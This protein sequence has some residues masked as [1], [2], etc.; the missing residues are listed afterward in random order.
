MLLI[1]LID[2]RICHIRNI[3]QKVNYFIIVYVLVI[4]YVSKGTGHHQTK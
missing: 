4:V 1:E 2:D 3:S